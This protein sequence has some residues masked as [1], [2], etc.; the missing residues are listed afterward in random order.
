MPIPPLNQNQK[1]NRLRQQGVFDIPVVKFLNH[2]FNHSPFPSEYGFSLQFLRMLTFGEHFQYLSEA[3]IKEYQDRRLR[4][5][6]LHVNDTVPYYKRWFREHGVDP[7][8]IKTREDIRKFPI[9]TKSTIKKNFNDFLSTRFNQYMPKLAM[10][11]GSTSAPFSFYLDRQSLLGEKAA[12]WKQWRANGV[13]ITSRIS[14]LRGTMEYIYAKTHDLTY[15]YGPFDKALHLN[16]FNINRGTALEMVREMN[17]FRPALFRVY[18]SSLFSLFKFIDPYHFS[19]DYLKCVHLSSESFSKE[20]R[21]RLEPHFDCPL[22][23]RYGQTEVVATAFECKPFGGYH[24]DSEKCLIEVL[25]PD[26]EPVGENHR[27]H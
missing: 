2:A 20:D 10:T 26:N 13:K 12:Y 19:G 21:K 11:S 17:Y 14:I 6:A 8:S 25:D 22:I 9:I 5:L 16:S 1:M 4:A 3:A 24:F 15:V 27:G 18:F 7:A 23:D